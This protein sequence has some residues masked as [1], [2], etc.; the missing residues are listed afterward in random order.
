MKIVLS[1]LI[2]LIAERKKAIAAFVAPLV[3]AAALHFNFHVDVNTATTIIVSLISALA[4][5]ET[6]NLAG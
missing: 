3:V 5:H 6:S 2:P 4:V 1:R